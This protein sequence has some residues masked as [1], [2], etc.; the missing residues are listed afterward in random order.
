MGCLIEGKTWHSRVQVHRDSD[1]QESMIDARTGTI[2]LGGGAKRMDR[3]AVA[4]E[5]YLPAPL[6]TCIRHTVQSVAGRL[7]DQSRPEEE[8]K[9]VLCAR[10][11][12]RTH[13]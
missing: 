13:A 9:E 4:A 11:G 7:D 8:K 10:S 1:G 12:I 6:D 3:P 5:I 2:G